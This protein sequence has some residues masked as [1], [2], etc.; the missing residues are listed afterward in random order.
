LVFLVAGVP[1]WR[2]IDTV[3]LPHGSPLAGT[4]RAITVALRAH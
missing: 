3:L 2:S 1:G 4:M